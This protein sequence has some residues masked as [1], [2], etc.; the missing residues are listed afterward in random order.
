MRKRGSAEREA[1][2]K[3]LSREM[4]AAE[5]LTGPQHVLVVA[6]HEID[7]RNFAWLSV[8][9][10]QRIDSLQRRGQ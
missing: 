6:G 7:R 9:G 3:R 2:G 8:P 1:L 4:D 5:Q 10:P